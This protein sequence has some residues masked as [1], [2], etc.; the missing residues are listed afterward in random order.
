MPVGLAQLLRQRVL[1][2]GGAGALARLLGRLQPLSLV[3]LLAILVLLFAWI[4][5]QVNMRVQDRPRG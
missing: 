3:A 2:A 4:R 5:I 1:A